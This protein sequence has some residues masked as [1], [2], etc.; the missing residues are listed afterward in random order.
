MTF[1]PHGGGGAD[2]WMAT[3]NGSVGV[4][5][6]IYPVAD[7]RNGTTQDSNPSGHRLNPV[8]D[9]SNRSTD[10]SY[11]A[12]DRLNL[13]ADRSNLFTDRS[14]PVADAFSISFRGYLKIRGFGNVN[15]SLVSSPASEGIEF[16][17]QQRL[18]SPTSPRYT[19][20]Q[21]PSGRPACRMQVRVDP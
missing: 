13:A 6:D 18:F 10:D 9:G 21:F 11:R 19:L 17:N 2:R 16:R 14:N 8:T 5:R 20:S 12:M 3:A 4:A 15:I 1:A 7:Q